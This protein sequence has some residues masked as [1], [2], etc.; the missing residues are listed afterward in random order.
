MTQESLGHAKMAG[1]MTAQVEQFP[2]QPGQ[3]IEI[4][5]GA[6]RGLQGTVLYFRG[7]G[8]LVV[9]ADAWGPGALL[10]VCERMVASP[11]SS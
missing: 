10:D 9:A 4:T 2:I 1:M 8:R 7:S 5:S 11:G 3:R 6:L